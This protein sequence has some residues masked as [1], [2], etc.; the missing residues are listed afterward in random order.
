MARRVNRFYQRLLVGVVLGIGVVASQSASVQAEVFLGLYGGGAFTENAEVRG[1]EK[2][3]P[4]AGG[5]PTTTQTF[6][7]DADFKDSFTVGGVL[8]IGQKD[9]HG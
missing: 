6:R 4:P 7:K 8:A 1:E 2:F 3:I 5:G 9:S